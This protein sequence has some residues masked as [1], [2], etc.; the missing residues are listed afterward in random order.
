MRIRQE[1]Q[2]EFGYNSITEMDGKY[3]EMLMDF[4]ILKLDTGQVIF[5]RDH[6]ERAFLLITGEVEFEWEDGKV[7][8][9]RISCFD[10]APWC[11]HVPADVSVRV[12]GIKRDTELSVH[13][14][15]NDQS[16]AARLFT[17]EDCRIEQRGAGT[18]KE[19]GTRIARTIFDKSNRDNSNLVLGEAI[20]FPGKWS[21][22]PPHHHPQ[23]EI[24]FYKFNL[25]NGF[26]YSE[27]GEEVYKVRNNDVI[28]LYPGMTHPQ[29]ASPGYAMYYTWVIRHLENLPYINPTFLPEHLWVT[30]K[31]A[32]IWPDT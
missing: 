15:A 6:K 3:S 14:T 29:V 9:T 20:T 1:K 31:D 4:G 2:F 25:E 32:R 18:M 24:Y 26:G 28:L 30:D 13:K 11:L 23:P 5:D 8:A 21:S 22:Y 19:A 27:V 16:F 12:S 17:P 7:V 10:E